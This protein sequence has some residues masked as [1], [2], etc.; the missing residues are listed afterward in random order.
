MAECW[1]ETVPVTNS[2]S[3]KAIIL[4]WTAGTWG[5]GGGGEQKSDGMA[6]GWWGSDGMAVG[7]WGWGWGE[8]RTSPSGSQTTTTM[9]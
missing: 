4:L 8:V 9:F 6:V 1:K 5:G 7:W 2:Y 3:I